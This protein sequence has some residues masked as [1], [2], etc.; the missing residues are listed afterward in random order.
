MWS[1][2]W[3][4]GGSAVNNNALF[5]FPFFLGGGGGDMTE[6]GCDRCGTGRCGCVD[7]IV[8]SVFWCGGL[9]L[10]GMGRCCC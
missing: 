8:R 7:E 2:L 3:L 9:V 1:R 10:I 5:L 6:W 4:F